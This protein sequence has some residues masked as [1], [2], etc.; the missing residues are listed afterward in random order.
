MI[1]LDS[2]NDFRIE[3]MFM[4]EFDKTRGPQLRYL[5]C[6]EGDQT[7]RHFITTAFKQNNDFVIPDEHICGRF[8]SLFLSQG[9]VMLSYAIEHRNDQYKR[10]KIEFDIGKD[11]A[12]PLAHS[13]N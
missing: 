13:H 1:N 12:F 10:G 9:L 4:G 6:F 5:K 7:M 3:A 2:Q 11:K 8:I